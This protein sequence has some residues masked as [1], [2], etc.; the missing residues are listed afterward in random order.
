M[1]NKIFDILLIIS[2]CTAL[3]C[4]G[5]V[6]YYNTNTNEVGNSIKSSFTTIKQEIVNLDTTDINR[7]KIPKSYTAAVP[8]FMYHFARDNVLPGEYAGNFI[9][10]DTL[11]DQLEY[12]TT[13]DYDVIFA[14]EILNAYDYEK[15]V[16][17]TFDDGF[18]CFYDN[19]YPLLKKYN[20]KATLFVIQ[21]GYRHGENHCTI[22]EIAEM[23]TSG[24]VEIEAHTRSHP[25]LSTLS[26]TEV[27]SELDDIKEALKI[28][29]D[30]DS[31]VLCYP[32]GDYNDM[33]VE[34]TEERY[35]MAYDMDGGVYY[36]N[37]H[38]RYNIP[39][40]YAHRDMSLNTFISYAQKADVE[41]VW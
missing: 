17:L 6:A 27:I 37:K 28:D 29:F 13:N 5:V 8:T 34:K 18:D 39:R 23:L 19:V 12:L 15:P 32:F 3:G 30:I 41:V 1:K 24:L 20:V 7:Y 16:I 33:V 14:G 22:S 21:S 25:Y 10:P 38:S 2:I 40:I 31:K 11:E 26:E 4:L 9:K 35:E 36:S